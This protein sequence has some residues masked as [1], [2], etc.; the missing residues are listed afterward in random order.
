MSEIVRSGR[1]PLAQGG[2]H[3]AGL[4]VRP[5]EML[6]LLYDTQPYAPMPFD[7][8]FIGIGIEDK[9]AESLIRFFYESLINPHENCVALNPH[10]F[11]TLLKQLADG[12]IPWDAELDGIEVSDKF[13]IILLR[14]KSDKFP[15][16]AGDA[17]PLIH[18]RYEGGQLALISPLEAI[19][20]DRRVQ[21]STRR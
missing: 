11:L 17:L 16:H 13:T 3:V 9:G 7:A 1:A 2:R 15:P 8:R 4:T 6:D 20:K 10:Y 12:M 5:E 19:K 21:I 14:L 18:L